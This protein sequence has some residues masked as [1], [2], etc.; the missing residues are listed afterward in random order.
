MNVHFWVHAIDANKVTSGLALVMVQAI[1]GTNRRLNQLGAWLS[2]ST[3][4]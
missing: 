3:M 1:S 2:V 4:Y